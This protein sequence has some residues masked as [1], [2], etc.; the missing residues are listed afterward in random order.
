MAGKNLSFRIR[1]NIWLLRLARNW[2]RVV[3]IV[4]GVY[5]TLPWVAPTLTQ[6]GLE[7]P[8]RALYS[9]YAPFC[10][11]FGFRSFFL[12]GDQLVYPRA[13]TGTELTPFEIPTEGVAALEAIE[14]LD[15]FSLDW[16]L[17]QKNFI[18]TEAMGYKTA[19]CMRDV[20]IYTMLF[21]G[22]LIY[23]IPKVRRRLRPVPLWLYVFLGVLPIAIDGFSQLLGYPP[24]NFWPP[25][26][27]LPIFRV[28]TGALFGIMSAWLG[29][30]YLELSFQDMKYEIERNLA[31]R[32][33]AV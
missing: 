33:I 3:L 4:L 29:F 14:P 26:E 9:M 22:G 5:A 24:F 21:V 32:G 30:P 7:G 17:A 31:R 8:G 2:L 6:I 11:Q 10:H 18:G 1:L 25:R 19:L 28:V 13:N 15:E 27:T 12:Y 20:A 23:A 16:S